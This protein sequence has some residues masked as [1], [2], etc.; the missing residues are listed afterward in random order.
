[1]EQAQ[2]KGRQP[3][4][5]EDHPVATKKGDSHLYL[6]RRAGY[7]NTRTRLNSTSASHSAS[8]SPTSGGQSGRRSVLRSSGRARSAS[9]DGLNAPPVAGASGSAR[10]PSRAPPPRP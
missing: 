8:A 4:I 10:A 5:K 9:G 6:W 3:G 2:V 1:R 7:S